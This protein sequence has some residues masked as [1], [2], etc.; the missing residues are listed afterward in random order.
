MFI[1]PYQH[2]ILEEKALSMHLIAKF[3]KLLSV[4]FLLEMQTLTVLELLIHQ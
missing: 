1:N 3:E 4:F 2:V